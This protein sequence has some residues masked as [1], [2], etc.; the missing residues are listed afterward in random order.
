[1]AEEKKK[2]LKLGNQKLTVK[3]H[4]PIFVKREE[5][6][7]RKVYAQREKLGTLE[8]PVGKDAKAKREKALKDEAFE[9]GF[10]KFMR[11]ASPGLADRMEKSYM[12]NKDYIKAKMKEGGIDR[13]TSAKRIA[14][15]LSEGAP[16]SA[17]KAARVHKK[18]QGY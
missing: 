12:N 8:A 16:E 17:K 3:E 15:G 5:D 14:K 6:R 9:L 1:M 2:K 4:L 11:Q 13:A 18:R 7:L 10:S